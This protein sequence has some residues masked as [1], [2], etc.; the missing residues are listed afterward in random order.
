MAWQSFF[1][2]TGV[3]LQLMIKKRIEIKKFESIFKHMIFKRVIS[4]IVFEKQGA[5]ALAQ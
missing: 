3:G 2:H 1:C 5:V 4:N